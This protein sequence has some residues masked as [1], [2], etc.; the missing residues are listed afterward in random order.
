MAD[1]VT[2]WFKLVSLFDFA[3]SSKDLILTPALGSNLIY[4]SEL[5]PIIEL[6]ALDRVTLDGNPLPELLLFSLTY[7]RESRVFVTYS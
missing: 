1:S 4:L 7:K 2:D 6:P 3:F 5:S